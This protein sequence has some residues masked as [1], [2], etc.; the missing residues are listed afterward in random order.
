MAFATLAHAEPPAPTAAQAATAAATTPS[1]DDVV[2]MK[3]GSR[4]HGELVEMMP[5]DHASITLPTG[6]I[7]VVRWDAITRVERATRVDVKAPPPVVPTTVQTAGAGQALV[8][9][10]TDKPLQ[11]EAHGVGREWRFACEAP[12]DIAL[13]LDKSYRI[14][15]DGVRAS[16]TFRIAA[17]PGGRVVLDVATA[18]KAGLVG[19]IVLASLGGPVMLVG[20]IVVAMSSITGSANAN[21]TGWIVFGVGAGSL[22]GGIILIVANGRTHVVQSNGN[23]LARRDGARADGF[24]R[25]PP[26]NDARL[27]AKGPTAKEAAPTVLVPIY[28]GSF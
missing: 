2:Y 6:Q 24:V 4:L 19:G 10:E 5:G 9:I 26:W 21:R 18:S 20:G 25:T 17:A 7:A 28:S 22:V 16:P 14:V 15:G 3:D 27:D 1:S 11:V 13:D 8:H 12:C 23:M